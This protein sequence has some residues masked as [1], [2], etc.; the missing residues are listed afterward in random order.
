MTDRFALPTCN[1]VTQLYLNYEHGVRITYT[2]S[3]RELANSGSEWN[4]KTVFFFF[5]YRDSSMLSYDAL[6][7]THT[8][9]ISER[10]GGTVIMSRRRRGMMSEQLKQE[11]AKDLGFYDTIQK[12]GWGGIRAKDA[13]NMVKR[14]IQ[15]AEQAAAQA[16]QAQ[17][18]AQAH[19]GAVQ[20]RGQV[21]QGQQS[22]VQQQPQY[23]QP[24]SQWKQQQAGYMPYMSQSQSGSETN[25]TPH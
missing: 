13:G 24:Q 16:Y 22:H 3:I 1:N 7:F 12:E 8:I 14:A 18:G 2:P 23:G 9:A 15:I 10:E 20:Y 25:H 17:S 11:L 21:Q 4:D 5:P 19:P 6:K